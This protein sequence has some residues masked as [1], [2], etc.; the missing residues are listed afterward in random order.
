MRILVGVDVDA[1]LRREDV[2]VCIHCVKWTRI[3]ISSFRSF[4]LLSLS[5]YVCLRLWS[6]RRLVISG[7]KIC[8]FILHIFVQCTRSLCAHYS[9]MN[10]VA[11]PPRNKQTCHFAIVPCLLYVC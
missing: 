3:S 6:V 11:H 4:Y 7:T 1:G 9:N 10:N 5:L 2:C 8:A